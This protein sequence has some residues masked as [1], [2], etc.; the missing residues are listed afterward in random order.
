MYR[1]APTC[2]LFGMWDSTGPKGGLGSKFQRSYVSEIVGFDAQ[3]GKKV[4]SRIDPLQIEKLAPGDRA[5]NSADSDEVWTFDPEE[6][7]KDKKRN[8]VYASRAARAARLGSHPR[9]TTATWLHPSTSWP[10][11][12]DFAGRSDNRDIVGRASSTAGSRVS[13]ARQN[14]RRER[15]W[16]PWV[17]P[18][19]RTS[20]RRIF[21]LRSRCLLLPTHPPRL[22]LPQGGWLRR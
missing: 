8:P 15:L 6:A 12:N 21:D 17:L 16:L 3:V 7:E 19:W 11:R 2:L 14:Q 13:T 1:Y 5:F 9:S 4:R 18:R 10:W 22:E 20:T